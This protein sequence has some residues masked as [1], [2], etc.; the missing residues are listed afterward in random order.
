MSSPFE[1]ADRLTESYADLD[2][3]EATI[4]GISGRE[5]LPTDFSPD[6]EEARAGLFRST[7]RE[8]APHLTHEDPIQRF[9]AEVMTGWLDTR[10]AEHDAGKWTWDAN[11][12]YSPFQWMC[13]V[14]D[15]MDKESAQGWEAVR[16]R[17][18]AFPDMVEGYQESLRVGLEKGMVAA[19][20]QVESVMEQ[21][22][23]AAGDQSRFLAFA[24]EASRAGVDS[25]PIAEAVARVREACADLADFF[26]RELLPVAPTADGAGGDLY[27]M[28]VDRYIGVELDLP[29]T[30]E[31]GWEEVRRLR[32]AMEQTAA[33][34]DA[35]L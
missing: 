33:E 9:A 3:L 19:R 31:W 15:V 35:E 8:L 2:P 1:I 18:E 24:G 34:V 30:Y 16:A 21:A 14:F 10:L 7:R 27:A 11:H 28:G 5:H 23:D 29:E 22:T 20:R 26:G 6:G 4:V 12:I 32:E 17:L 13:D 25:A